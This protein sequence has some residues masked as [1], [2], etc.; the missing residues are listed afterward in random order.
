MRTKSTSHKMLVWDSL[1]GELLVALLL[2]AVAVSSLAVLMYSV[3]R[4][5]ESEPREFVACAAKNGETAWQLRPRPRLQTAAS[6]LLRSGCAAKSA[7][8][9]AGVKPLLVSTQPGRD[10]SEVTHRFGVAGDGKKLEAARAPPQTRTV[11]TI[12]PTT[13]Q[14]APRVEPWIA[15]M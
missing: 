6:K 4:R 12:R 14:L 13:H 15:R 1:L 2:L 5:P 3:S 7:P 10:D 11:G 8:L 9:L